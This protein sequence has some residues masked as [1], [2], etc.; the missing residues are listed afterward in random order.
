MPGRALL[1]GHC[2]IDA[3]RIEAVL[4]RAGCDGVEGVQ[5][6]DG[7]LAKLRQ[8]RY[9]LV[10]GNRV[11]GFDQ[12]GGLHLT[13]KVRAAGDLAA[14]PVMVLSGEEETQRAVAAAGGLAGFGKDHLEEPQ[15]PAR[16]EA[17]FR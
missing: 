14:V 9:R 16:F 2:P 11:I 4:R 1:V 10:V 3:P 6:V 5:S 17:Y 12:Q 13:Q 7:A 8:G 15:T